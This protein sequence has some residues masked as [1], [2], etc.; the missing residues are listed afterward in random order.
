MCIYTT[1]FLNV[2]VRSVLGLHAPNNSLCNFCTRAHSMHCAFYAATQA[3]TAAE[4]YDLDIFSFSTNTCFD[5]IHVHCSKCWP[6]CALF[7]VCVSVYATMLSPIC[8]EVVFTA[9]LVPEIYEY[10]AVN[11]V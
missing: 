5:P 7:G 3:A 10:C 9:K 1:F 8:N 6:N 4:K 11:D 2:L